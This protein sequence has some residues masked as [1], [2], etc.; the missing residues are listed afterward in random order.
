MGDRDVCTACVCVVHN[1]RASAAQDGRRRDIAKRA[2]AHLG[3]TRELDVVLNIDS[4]H[5]I[6][7]YRAMQGP[8]ELSLASPA[9]LMLVLQNVRHLGGAH[10]R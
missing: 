2:P 5:L 3:D 10:R 6:Y 1:R 8:E 4:C 7:L 9:G